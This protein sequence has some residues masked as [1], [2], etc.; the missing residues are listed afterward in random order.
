MDL[1][2]L[3]VREAFLDAGIVVN[4]SPDMLQKVAATRE[5]LVKL[6]EVHPRFVRDCVA[7]DRS[8]SAN[9]RAEG[10]VGNLKSTR[11]GVVLRGPGL[12]F[13]RSIRSVD[14]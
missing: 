8:H 9:S 11:V 12:R 3:K 6:L 10:A 2:G 14:Q 1:I 7:R 13:G 5:Q 4:E